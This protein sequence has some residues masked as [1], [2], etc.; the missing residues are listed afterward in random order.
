MSIDTPTIDLKTQDLF[1][2]IINPKTKGF[3]INY[4]NENHLITIHH[5]LPIQQALINN[6]VRK[7][8]INSCWSEILILDSVSN[9]DFGF[10]VFKNFHVKVPEKNDKLALKI[11]NSTINL[12]MDSHAFV[13]FNNLPKGPDTVYLIA[14]F[15]N[16]IGNPCGLSGCPVF[17]NNKLVGVFSKFDSQQNKCLIIPIYIVLKNL[18]KKDNNN[19]YNLSVPNIKKLNSNNI[20]RKRLENNC[21]KDFIFHSALKIHIPI[22]V[23][24]LLEGDDNTCVICNFE[25]ESK[26]IDTTEIKYVVVNDFDLSI[27]KDLIRYETDSDL[28]YKLN[29]RIFILI[30]KLRACDI[31]CIFRKME[32]RENLDSL[33]IIMSDGVIQII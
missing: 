3:F 29:L 2:R 17:Y 25:N 11:N 12:K 5:H 19:I 7:I 28:Y 13:S 23:Y 27:E 30:H 4:A 10:K 33:K 15:E 16:F 26:N 22:D 6:D 14:T 31:T 32:K 8:K 9:D 1:G 24:Y 20:T 18:E 21:I